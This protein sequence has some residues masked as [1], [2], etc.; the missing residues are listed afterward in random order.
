MAKLY[1]RKQTVIIFI[2]CVVVVGTMVWYS[3]RQKVAPMQDEG[4]IAV[5]TS[6]NTARVSTTTASTD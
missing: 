6:I 5:T 2:A 4:R 3:Y 1:P